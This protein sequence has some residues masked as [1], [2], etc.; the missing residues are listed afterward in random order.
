MGTEQMEEQSAGEGEMERWRARVAVG[1]GSKSRIER[2]G[3][4]W[5]EERMKRRGNGVGVMAVVAQWLADSNGGIG[6]RERAVEEVKVTG[7]EW[8]AA[9]VWYR[10]MSTQAGRI[11]LHQ[12]QDRRLGGWWKRRITEIEEE[13]RQEW[14]RTGERFQRSRDW[15]R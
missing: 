3:I 9:V 6:V 15:K 12:W 7:N 14:V 11:F 10:Q 4:R 1:Q 8:E 5:R 13:A 2:E